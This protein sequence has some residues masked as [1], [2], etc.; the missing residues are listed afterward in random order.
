MSNKI[1]GRREVSV[2]VRERESCLVNVRISLGSHLGLG[3]GKRV[4]K[5]GRKEAANRMA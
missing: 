4:D 3:G 2:R 1:L 5:D